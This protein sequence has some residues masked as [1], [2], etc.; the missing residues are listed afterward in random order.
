M[1][2]II[3]LVVLTVALVAFVATPATA[4]VRVTCVATGFVDVTGDGP[5]SWSVSGAGP[6]FD[7]LQGTFFVNFSGSGTSDSL[8]LCGDL[9][10][11]NLNLTVNH[12]FLNQRTGVHTFATQT[13]RAPVTTFPIATPFFIAQD[14]LSRGLGLLSTRVLLNCP[15]GGSNV[16]SFIL[17]TAI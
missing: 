13:W 3:A 8:G 4:A 17:A 11:T 9:V 16:A 7:T 14:G 1:R 5:H 2:R 15:P 6:C 10:V 12:D